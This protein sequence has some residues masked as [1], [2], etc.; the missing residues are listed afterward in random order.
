M[1]S[2]T[3]L[4]LLACLGLTVAAVPRPAAADKISERLDALER[5]NA[6]L[7]ARLNRLE[8]PRAAK[9]QP[10]PADS[11][12]GPA[13]VALPRSSNANSMAADLSYV[14]PRRPNAPRFEVWGTLSFLQPGAG[15]LEYGTLTNPLPP[16]TPHWQNQSLRPDFTP[17]F[18][19]GARYMAN[20]SNDIQLKL[21][22]SAQHRECF[23]LCFADA[24]GGTALS[25][26][27]G[28]G[29]VQERLWLG[30]NLL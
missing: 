2:V 24:D 14:G 29:L 11:G 26:R 28:I 10:R 6:A 16:V 12:S 7:R 15:N 13:L 4:A 23:V 17:S 20:E 3:K 5:E 9:L 27:A 30:E 8:T 22:A 1:N 21:D 18:T 19:L 25:D